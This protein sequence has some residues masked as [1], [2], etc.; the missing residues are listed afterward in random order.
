MSKFQETLE[1]MKDEYD[2]QIHFNECWDETYFLS[3]SEVEDWLNE[4]DSIIK[5]KRYSN[6][7]KLQMIV[8]SITSGDYDM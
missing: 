5:S 8:D 7:K 2:C 1:S 3:E 4:I 6:Q